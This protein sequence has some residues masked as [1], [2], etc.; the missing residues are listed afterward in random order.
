MIRLVTL[1][2]GFATGYV[3]GTRAGREKYEQI[4][5][6]AR[7]VSGSPTLTR[8]QSSAK[9]LL[10]AGVDPADTRPRAA[11]V[12]KSDEPVAGARPAPLYETDTPSG[13]TTYTGGTL[14]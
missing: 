3:L 11:G 13:P 7:K 4:A 14:S 2:A 9:A 1:A 6:A 12:V 8:A 5:A 10:D